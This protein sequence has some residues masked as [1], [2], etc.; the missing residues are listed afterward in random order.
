MSDEIVQ[1]I[2]ICT[3]MS[4]RI[5]THVTRFSVG[6]DGLGVTDQAH[7]CLPERQVVAPDSGLADDYS[8]A[9]K[10]KAEDLER[11]ERLELARLKAKYGG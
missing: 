9:I 10:V 7:Y 2:T 11:R 3:Y 5:S 4:G 8:S 6:E 1:S